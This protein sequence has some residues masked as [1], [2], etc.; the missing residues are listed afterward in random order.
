MN[1]ILPVVIGTTVVCY[2]HSFNHV[3]KLY[4][5]SGYTLTWEEFT[6]KNVG[7]VRSLFV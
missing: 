4:K 2:V 1:W 6:D 3:M 7:A 5:D